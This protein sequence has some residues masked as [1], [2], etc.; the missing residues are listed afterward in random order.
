M[1]CGVITSPREFASLEELSDW[2]M[3]ITTF[4]RQNGPS[5]KDILAA[6]ERRILEVYIRREEPELRLLAVEI[7]TSTQVMPI[8]QQRKLDLV[9]R[10]RLRTGLLE[11]AAENQKA[12]NQII[13][14]GKIRDAAEYRLLANRADELHADSARKEEHDAI[15]GLLEQYELVRS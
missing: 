11:A 14:C 9:L 6:L 8:R 15:M 7:A 3:A 1:R 2:C 12:V 4:M 13:R 5:D 10:S